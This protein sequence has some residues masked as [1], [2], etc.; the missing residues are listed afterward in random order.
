MKIFSAT[1]H[2]NAREWYGDLPDASITTMDQLEE[3]FL[4]RCG[5]KLEDIQNLLKRLDYIKQIKIENFREFHD[6]F[7]GLFY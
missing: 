3:T 1:L 4:K 2:G 5:I 6:R 7:E